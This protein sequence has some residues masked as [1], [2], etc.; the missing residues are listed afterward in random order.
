M[1]QHSQ[2]LQSS[3]R[4]RDSQAWAVEIDGKISFFDRRL[5]DFFTQYIPCDTPFPGYRPW[6]NP[7]DVFE[8]VPVDVKETAKYPELLVGLRSLVQEFEP[9]RRPLFAEGSRCRV[10]FPFS[11]WEDERNYTMPGILMSFPGEQDEGWAGTWHGISM[12]FEIKRTRGED[13]IDEYGVRYGKQAT[14]A[15]TQLAKSARNLLSTHGMLFVYVVGI[16]GDTARIYRFDHAACVVSRSFDFKETPWPLHELLW[17]FCYYQGPRGGAR[18]AS[19]PPTYMLIGADPSVQRATDE[20]LR[21]AEEKYA[22]VG[23]E[24]LTLTDKQACRWITVTRHSEDGTEMG[25][26]RYLAYRIRSLNA[27]LFSRATAV[28]DALEEGTWERCVIKDS[29]RQLEHDR[30]DVLYDRIRGSFRDRPWHEVLEDHVFMHRNDGPKEKPS[31]PTGPFQVDEQGCSMLP[32]ELEEM[33]VD[34]ALDPTI[35]ELYG[36]P[37]ISYSDDL[38]AREASKA[39]RPDSSNAAGN[40]G[41]TGI[42]LR[43]PK[44]ANYYER[45]HMRVI[46]KT[47]GRPL[48]S[49]KSTK[50]L[51]RALRD[52]II[53]H[54]QAYQAGVIHRDISE[55][56]VMI[57][58]TSIASF[59]GF[60][61]DFD[62]GFDWKA[63]LKHAGL[64][65]TKASWKTFVEK[66]NESL[67]YRHRPAPPEQQPVLDPHDADVTNPEAKAAREKWE[68]RMKMRERTGTLDFMAMEIL[69][70]YLAHDVRHDLESFFW[71]LLWIVSRHTSNTSYPTYGVYLDVFDT[72][73][74]K[75]S[76]AKKITFLMESMPFQVKDNKPLTTLLR[77]FKQL[78]LH[79]VPRGGEDPS[80]IVPLTYESVLAVF[81]KALADPSWPES[82]SALPFKLP[83]DDNSSEP[84]QDTNGSSAGSPRDN[85]RA[86]E[87]DSE[88]EGDL[89]MPQR[90]PKRI[91]VE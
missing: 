57:C 51:V 13:P 90:A 77:D 18:V 33:L 7:S 52:A 40:R 58:D 11:T 76:A 41:S 59:T 31:I 46:M 47:V 21:L 87:A 74:E 64:P 14:D 20:D 72:H 89:A 42:V 83:R 19:A 24:P 22:K 3:N 71:L 85:K 48:S 34:A 27:R 36:L 70:S 1:T 16:Y 84:G 32:L 69:H 86:R 80:T 44:N 26:T 65:V 39:L 62:Y 78:C 49:F 28:W 91:Q 88:D 81:D 8:A 17:R 23:T 37:E 60:L 9:E 61:L 79:N 67:P 35:A 6:G 5:P 43:D 68:V 25:T 73:Q 54:R 53:G 45:S 55:G 12:V 66:Y 10:K 82:D 38:G 29:W 2:T 15:L 50:E 30:E 63:A 75:S 4:N 56:N